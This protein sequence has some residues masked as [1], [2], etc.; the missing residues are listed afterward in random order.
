VYQAQGNYDEALVQHQKSLKINIRVLG[1]AHEQ[2]AS[3][4]NKIGNVFFAQGD[5]EN[6]LLQHQKSLEIRSGCSAAT[7]RR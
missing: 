4:F 2:V 3:S 5:Y 1:C 6:A 7:L